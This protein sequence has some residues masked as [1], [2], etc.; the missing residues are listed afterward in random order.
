MTS[1]IFDA[2]GKQDTKRKRVGRKAGREKE[3][4]KGNRKGEGK[5]GRK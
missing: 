2:C 5:K 1:V 3:E 4:K